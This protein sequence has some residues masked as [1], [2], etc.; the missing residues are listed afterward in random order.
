MWY[1][2]DVMPGA[3]LVAGLKTGVTKEKFAR[4]IKDN[5]IEECLLE[6][7]VEPGDVVNIPA[8]LVHSIGAGIVIAEIQQTSDTNYR[9]FDYNRVDSKGVSRQLHLEKALD[10]INFETGSRNF[11]CEGVNI[12]VNESCNKTV[13]LANTY[14][15]CERYEVNGSFSETCD[16]SKFNIFICL[17]G[18]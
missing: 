3:K 17:E 1:I 4:A 12:K 11:K 2:I 16:G 7:G 9:I 13:F 5:R 18:K 15:A 6:V 8:G 10:V 14:F